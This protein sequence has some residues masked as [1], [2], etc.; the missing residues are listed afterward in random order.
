[1]TRKSFNHEGQFI[2][3]STSLNVAQECLRKYYYSMILN[4]EPKS[5]S[6]HLIFGGIYAKALETFYL[7]RAEG[8]SIDE[9]LRFVVRQALVESWDREKNEPL[10][11]DSAAKTRAN[12]IRTIVWYVDEFAHENESGIR[13]HHLSNGKPAVE[14]SFVLELDDVFMYAGHLDRVVAYGDGLYWMDQKT[15]GSTISSYFF[16][17]FKPSNQFY[18]YTWA[19]QT[20]LKS[21]VRGGII[22]AAQIA[23]G[24][25]RFARQPI[26]VTKDTLDE[27]VDTARHTMYGV[28]SAYML[29]KW[30]MNLTSCGNYGGCP[31]RE[32]CT[33]PPSVREKFVE[34]NYQVRTQPWDPATPR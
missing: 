11:F 21:P 17:Q 6:V 7:K 18:G 4:L 5:K 14:L 33:R 10:H 9:A 8:M 19:G 25:S 2:F 24:F 15:T 34:G 29:Q 13:T 22:D 26:T 16:D 1:M 12:L 3:D 23:Q 27:W 31:F 20:I 30:P 28:R 32:L